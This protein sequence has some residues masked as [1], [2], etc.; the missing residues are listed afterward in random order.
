V[1]RPFRSLEWSRAFVACGLR[2][3]TSAIELVTA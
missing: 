1:H 2:E 3:R